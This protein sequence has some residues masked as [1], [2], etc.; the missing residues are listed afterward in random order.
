M[1]L[2]EVK[3]LVVNYGAI[4][5]V[6]GIDLSIE[7]GEIITLLG[8]NGAGKT[9]T[10]NA[11][12]HLVKP[13]EGK[14]AFDGSDI[15][16]AQTADIVRMGISLA[17]EG[18]Q[19]FAR[20]TTLENLRMGGYICEEAEIQRGIE[21][22]YT[23]F[24]ILKQRSKQIAGTLSGGEQQMLSI[25]RALMSNPRLLML[26]EPSLGLAPLIIADVFR[27]IREIN[28]E[29]GTSILLVEQNARVA[30]GVSNRAYVLEKGRI[31][32]SGEASVL[33]NDD[34]V[35]KAYLGG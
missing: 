1:S 30:L 2:L 21:R 23:L 9:S 4:N 10:L 35:I 17:M 34:R 11:I 15:S 24:P 31:T 8:A 5:A 27:A 20:M 18:R 29:S 26:D 22:A 14:I 28:E 6:Q 12:T 32:L 3:G 25:A 19:I 33:L 16:T 7:K 13:S